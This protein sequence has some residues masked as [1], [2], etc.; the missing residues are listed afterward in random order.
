MSRVIVLG[1][2][3][4]GLAAASALRG[5]LPAEDEVV[6]V[7]RTDWFAVGFRKTW[8]LL[9]PGAW[10]EGIR[11][12]TPLALRG[13]QFV[14]GEVEAIHPVA[15][16]ADVGGARLRSDGLIVA[17]G[18][19]QVP[20]A[21]P[22]FSEHGHNPYAV[23]DLAQTSKALREFEGGRLL[24]GVMGE[25]HPCPPAPYEIA[26][27]LRDF[28]QERDIDVDLGVFTPKPSSLPIAGEA[29]CMI[30]E[31][32]LEAR[33]IEFLPNRR[34]MEVESG[35]VQFSSAREDFDLLLGIPPHRAPDV[36]VEAGLT[37]ESGWIEP[38]AKTLRTEYEGVY[39]IGDLTNIQ[40]AN[41]K[42]LPMAGVFAEAQGVAA[43]EDIAAL[44]QGRE[45]E[46]AFEGEGGCFLE[47][48]GGEAVQVQGRFLA[49]DGPQVEVTE[50]SADHL[51]AK[52]EFEQERL[53]RWFGS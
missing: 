47:V 29:G 11:S 23:G 50:P 32:R 18:A 2:G 42:P 6:L 44:I 7:D 13:I 5:R 10:E 53:Q 28:Y 51:E 48:G 9:D 46:A 38:D 31:D 21:V 27:L 12:L 43:A 8:A 41:G 26:Y 49:E 40:M 1:G 4:G 14:Q 3:F 52:H 20:G 37:G 24:V 35:T 25:P 30:I 17:L 19:E 22:G 36:V 16:T 15:K 39:A 34:A 33:G 45:S